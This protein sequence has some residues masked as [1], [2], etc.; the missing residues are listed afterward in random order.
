MTPFR[1]ASL[2][3]LLLACDASTGTDDP[4]AMPDAGPGPAP[5][6]APPPELGEPIVIAPEDYGRWVW[7]EQPEMVCADGSPGGF[8]VNMLDGAGEL[9]LFL[10]G[11][12]ICYDPLSC[13]VGGAP[14]NVGA[15]PLRTA[16]DGRIRDH[17]GIFDRDDVDNPFRAASYVVVPHCTGDFHL[18]T[19]VTTHAGIGELHH[20][21]YLNIRHL[22]S[23]L[24]PTFRDAQR[25]TVAGFSAGGVGITGNYQQIAAAFAVVNQPPPTLI[26][27]GS[28]LVRPPFLTLDAQDDL[29][30]AWGLDGVAAACPSCLT[31]GFHEIYRANLERVPGLRSSL[32]CAYEDNVVVT[33]F[34]LLNRDLTYNGTRLRA[35][36]VDLA[37]WAAT[38][39]VPGSTHRTLYF[40]G[41]RHAALNEPLANTPGLAAFLRAQLD[42][43][44]TW[45]DVRP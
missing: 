9:L 21:G 5:D 39:A 31:D 41:T 33:L 8:A 16:L 4:G 29:E 32:L 15:D 22:L 23:R 1:L 24:V 44:A 45:T 35:G 28:P 38:L 11:G 18:G 12:G 27:D 30:R 37:D 6:A 17:V 20:V 19:K 14:R 25:V 2:C 10:Q 42:P 7:I 40:P 3:S 13:N 26:A 36:L 43:S 34:G